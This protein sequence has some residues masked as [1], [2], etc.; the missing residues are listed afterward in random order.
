MRKLSVYV[1]TEALAIAGAFACLAIGF[2]LD[3]VPISGWISTGVRLFDGTGGF[4]T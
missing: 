1:S 2:C 3:S 4:Y